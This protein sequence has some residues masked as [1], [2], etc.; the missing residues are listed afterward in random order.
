[1]DPCTAGTEAARRLSIIMAGGRITGSLSLR[2]L[3]IQRN[4]RQRCS[5]RNAFGDL[6]IVDRSGISPARMARDVP[7]YRRTEH[8][9]VTRILQAVNFCFARIYHRVRVL[10]PCTIPRTGPA[11]LVCN[12]ISGLDPILI[13]SACH[14]LIRWMVAREY[15][16]QTGVKWLL[17]QV[18]AIPVDRSRH[19]LAATRAALDALDAGY[20]LGV[21]P[22]GRIEQSNELLPFQS[23]IVLL[24]ARSGAPVYPAC[25]EGTQRGKNMLPAF[26]IPNK[27]LLCFGP[28]L[29]LNRSASSRPNLDHSAA[30]IQ[31]SVEQ[32][33]ETCVSTR[34]NQ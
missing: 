18:G 19:D 7:V 8:H 6:P 15:Y 27:T 17:D 2:T 21:F 11:I 20:V 5:G 13:Q 24:A 16:Q 23:G 34:K 26:F 30:A 3:N 4:R 25:L 31:K 12:H 1:M 9:P 14:R 28:P 32:L 29:V 33:R 22:E 10:S